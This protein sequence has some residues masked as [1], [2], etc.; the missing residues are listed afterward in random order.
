MHNQTLRNFQKG[1]ATLTV[2]VVIL[3]IVT[4]MV[5]YATKVGILDQRMAGNEVRYKEA[6][7]QAEAGLDFSTQRFNSAFTRLYD[8]SNAAASLATVLANSQVGAAT[9]SD[10]TSP[11]SGEGSFTVNVAPSGASFGSVPIYNFVST[12]IGADGTGTATVQRQITMSHALGGTVPDIPIIVGGVVG[13]SG[14]FNIVGNPNGAGPGIPVS[15]WSN[16]NITA[17][18]SSATCHIQYYDGNNAQCSNPS[19]NQENI[20]RGTNPATALTTYSSSMPD[21][22]PNDPNFPTDLFAFLFN[23][24]RA[25]W[26]TKKAEA[27]AHGQVVSNCNSIVSL[28]TNAGNNFALWWITGACD[29]GSNAVIGSIAKPVILVIDDSNLTMRAGSKLHGIVYIFNNPDNVATPSASFNGS[30]EIQGSI[31]SDMG[32]AQMNGSF[33]VVYNPT[34]VNSFVNGG[35]SNFTIAYVPGSWRDF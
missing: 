13:T 10:G 35:G 3:V 16:A 30:P 26:Q 15:I 31:I 29:T 32:G 17:S 4:L 1:V 9:E 25:D 19:G 7:A 28:G 24:D 27:E 33:S 23:I 11:E 8:G 18:S 20:T 14:N 21:L 12:G 22:L 5:A 6:F 2:T 34:V